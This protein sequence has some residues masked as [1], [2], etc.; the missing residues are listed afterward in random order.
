MDMTRSLAISVPGDFIADGIG[1]DI[2][3][4]VTADQIHG[5]LS[6]GFYTFLA[7]SR[8]TQLFLARSPPWRR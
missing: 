2:A 4:A 1:K 3:S 5:P 6:L 7:G 8:E